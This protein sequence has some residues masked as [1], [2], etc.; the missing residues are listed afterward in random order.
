[1]FNYRSS[2]NSLLSL[3]VKEFRKSVKIGKVRGKRLA[4]PFSGQ[5]VQG[6][7][8]KKQSLTEN[9]MSPQL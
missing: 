6:A 2:R 9:P 3:K 8:I 1:M 5:D 4:A 7:P